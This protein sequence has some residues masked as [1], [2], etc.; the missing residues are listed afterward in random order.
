MSNTNETK[1]K[2]LIVKDVGNTTSL[3][4]MDEVRNHLA[5]LDEDGNLDEDLRVYEIVRELK[6]KK[7]FKLL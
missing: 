6:V 3:N 1:H 7:E 5:E 2:F 4:S